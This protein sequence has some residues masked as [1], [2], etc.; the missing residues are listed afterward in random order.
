MTKNMGY[1]P[2]KH[3]RKYPPFSGYTASFA[4]V[5]HTRVLHNSLGGGVYA[6][7]GYTAAAL[8]RTASVETNGKYPADKRNTILTPTYHRKGLG[9]RLTAHANSIADEAGHPTFVQ[10]RP[11]AFKMLETT[12]FVLGDSTVF[13]ATKFGWGDD[14][15]QVLM[16]A[17]KRDV[18]GRP[19]DG[20]VN[21]QVHQ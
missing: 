13:D 15:Q 1:D 2:A 16:R 8:P 4:I 19:A 18:G 21:G 5:S 20:Q 3:F 6:L 9:T 17:Y 11:K 10:A 7:D 12:G 14:G